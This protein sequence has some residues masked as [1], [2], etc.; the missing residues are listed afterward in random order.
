MSRS[1]QSGWSSSAVRVAAEQA[2]EAGDPL[3]QDRVALVGHRRR[4]L[5]AG[6]ERLLDL[7]DLG[8]LEV[9]DL[10]REALERAADDRDRREERRVAVA[11]DDLGARPGP[12]AARA[13]E[14]LRLD[15]RAEVAVRPDRAG[16]LA[17]GDVVDR[18][19]EAPRPRSSSNAQPASFRPNV[20]GSAWTEW[21]GP[22][23]RSRPPRG[24]ARSARRA[25]GRSRE[26]DLAGGPAA[27]A[28][29]PCRPRR[30][31]SG[32]GGGS[33][34]PR[35]T[36]SATWLTNAITSWS[37]VRSISA[38]RSGSTRRLLDRASAVRGTRP[39]GD[40][41]RATASSTREHPLEARAGRS[42]PRPSRGACSAGSRGGPAAGDTRPMSWRRCMP[43]TRSRSAAAS[44]ASRAAP[45]SAPRPTTVRTRPPS[46]VQP[47]AGRV[48]SRR[49]RRAPPRG[50][51]VE[52]VDP[53][54]PSGRGRVAAAARTIPTARRAGRHGR[55]AARRPRRG[56]R[57]NGPS[58]AASRG[59]GSPGPRG[60]RSG[61]CTRGAGA[62]RR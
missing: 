22:S 24:P 51:L 6:L 13:R 57:S 4:A 50:G 45:R 12:R 26:Q 43:P 21:V 62:R 56:G 61:R 58:G 36:V 23:S 31:E 38:I 18:G 17:R 25:G 59:A 11:L 3:G 52:P 44:A 10:G 60:R 5:L 7:A 41:A 53:V 54:A 1:C 33:A 34:R 48:A 47:S 16:D 42:R 8:V 2:G 39:R 40:C 32:R 30:S 14:H 28:R 46:V 19:G 27:G 55:G 20:I 9:A 29:A 35:P 15:V 37:V 49:G